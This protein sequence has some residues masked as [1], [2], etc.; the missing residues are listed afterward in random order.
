MTIKHGEIITLTDNKEYVIVDFAQLG[1]FEYLYLIEQNDFN[2]KV[3]Y[4]KVDDDKLIKVI[5]KEL[6][7]RLTTYF[8][9]K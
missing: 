5:D 6:I 1:S 7:D 4:K 2:N 8:N 3:F 9:N